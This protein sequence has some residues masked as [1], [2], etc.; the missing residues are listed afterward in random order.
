[1]LTVCS[2]C[3]FLALENC[4]FAGPE[5]IRHITAENVY[6]PDVV[7][8][9]CHLGTALS[10]APV[11]RRRKQSQALTN[12]QHADSHN[13]SSG[14]SLSMSTGPNSTLPEG[15]A[16]GVAAVAGT[17]RPTNA[18]QPSDRPT[19]VTNDGRISTCSYTV[20]RSTGLTS[21]S[22]DSALVPTS[23][24]VD[25]A[26]AAAAA[27]AMRGA[28]NRSSTSVSQS[29]FS[30]NS[31]HG[32]SNANNMSAMDLLLGLRQIY[33]PSTLSVIML[34]S[35]VQ[36]QKMP[37]RH[38]S[39]GGYPVAPPPGAA[40]AEGAEGG[41][42][43]SLAAHTHA[44]HEGVAGLMHGANDYMVLPVLPVELEAR[45]NM[46]V[47]KPYTTHTCKHIRTHIRAHTHIQEKR[48]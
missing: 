17:D 8:L 34:A 2:L 45:I 29:P 10:G 24:P 12:L 6:L 4:V 32:S 1:M 41:V 35:L 47:R 48:H 46:Q 30:S 5:C 21:V 31:A 25:A 15:T 44:A 26:A 42:V 7:L 40:G 20:D 9:D 16:A 27:A 38:N 11:L 19:G 13:S 39:A 3:V 36:P 37:A 22:T 43:A 28:S 23:A 14:Q 18:T 33:D